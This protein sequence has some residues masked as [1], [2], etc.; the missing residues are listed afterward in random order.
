MR[1]D[2]E[3][4]E[5]NNGCSCEE[6][7]NQVPLK[8][9]ISVISLLLS[10]SVSSLDNSKKLPSHKMCVFTHPFRL[11]IG[12]CADVKTE[13]SEV[14]RVDYDDRSVSSHPAVTQPKGLAERKQ[15]GSV[16][17]HKAHIIRGVTSI[18]ELKPSAVPLFLQFKTRYIG[19]NRKDM[20][21]APIQTV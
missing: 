17:G 15:N 1:V 2:V 8:T 18:T 20:E 5:F 19:R 9:I 10:V 12:K 13:K 7:T 21:K 11:I 14:E 6:L 16:I 3:K 4:R